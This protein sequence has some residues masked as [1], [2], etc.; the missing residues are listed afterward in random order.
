M[1]ILALIS[2]LVVLSTA[3]PY[4]VL[5]ASLRKDPVTDSSIYAVS[6]S[7]GTPGNTYVLAVDFNDDKIRTFTP[8]SVISSSYSSINGGSDIVLV[9]GKIYR[10]PISTLSPSD[11][12]RSVCSF[13]N[14]KFGFSR[15]SFVWKLW[16]NIGF[17]MGSITLGQSDNSLH[18]GHQACPSFQ[19]NCDPR[20]HTGLCLT[21]ATIS[22]VP[23]QIKFTAD[24][25]NTIP[26]QV[27][28]NY[29]GT[30]NVY[31]SN[32]WDPLVIRI[33]TAGQTANGV[34]HSTPH[35]S[36]GLFGGCANYPYTK[37]DSQSFVSTTQKGVKTLKLGAGAHPSMISVGIGAWSDMKVNVD[38]LNG[39]MSIQ[40]YLTSE[41]IPDINLF[42]FTVLLWC[43]VRWKSTDTR[44]LPAM[45]K[46]SAKHNA[47]TVTYMF[48]GMPITFYAFFSY[49]T[50]QIMRDYADADVGVLMFLCFG[51]VTIVICWILFAAL[52]ENTLNSSFRINTVKNVIYE[53]M[54]ITGMWL[55][56]LV[57]RSDGLYTLPTLII[58]LMGFYNLSYHYIRIL[59][60]CIYV[61]T[62]SFFKKTVFT[63]YV[64]TLLPMLYAF[65]AYI[66]YLY[67]AKPLIVSAT[68]HI[69]ADL[70]PPIA[71]IFFMMILCMASYMNTVYEMKAMRNA[72]VAIEARKKAGKT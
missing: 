32:N 58:N 43:L 70:S 26:S 39:S 66:T 62:I 20:D 44:L 49:S 47:V 38:A 24:H 50:R 13:C 34:D 45:S 17:S 35:E 22:G 15:T 25:N 27:F 1:K 16:P 57:R 71:L 18:R 54:L 61:G 41:H 67:F 19:V 60:Y 69:S 46:D 14:G 33:L 10:F 29:I 37:L 9:S 4:S 53:H 12:L 64:I 40:M 56:L 42:L 48:I 63:M 5:S 55:L 3:A 68:S 31:N 36:S 21:N 59:T 2:I 28:D 72:S 7:I 8:L 11:P 51:T 23:Y 65:Q 6:I 30:K 52:K